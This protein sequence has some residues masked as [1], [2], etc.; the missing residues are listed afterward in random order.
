[1]TLLKKIYT[2][3]YKT[4]KEQINTSSALT[5]AIQLATH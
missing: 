5:S 2:D 4:E 3:V 1:M